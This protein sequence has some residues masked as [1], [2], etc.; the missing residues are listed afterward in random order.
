M[1]S[2][3]LAQAITERSTTQKEALGKRILIKGKEYV[4]CKGTA[5]NTAGSWVKFDEAH[6]VV[7]LAPDM[8]GPV[9]IS[10]SAFVANE[11]GWVQVKG[12]NTAAKTDTIAADAALYIDGTSGRADDLAVTGDLILGAFSET[13]DTTNVATVYLNYPYVTNILG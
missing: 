6:L 10:M 9:G 12:V 1:A 8:V 11:Y 7:L 13:A 2:E 4:Y 3:A 5:S